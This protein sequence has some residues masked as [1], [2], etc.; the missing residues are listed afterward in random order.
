MKRLKHPLLSITRFSHMAG[1]CFGVLGVC[2]AGQ[3][4]ALPD[5]KPAD[6]KTNDTVSVLGFKINLANTKVVAKPVVPAPGTEVIGL[7]D[8]TL[9]VTQSLN[10]DT[11]F[12]TYGLPKS[13]VYHFNVKGKWGVKLDVNQDQGLSDHYDDVDAGAYYKIT[14]S[15]HVGGSVGVGQRSNVIQPVDAQDPKT[16]TRVRVETSYNF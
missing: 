5:T 7:S 15:L 9:R 11:P 10:Q 8:Q 1:L 4:L 6:N 14:P 3:A 13:H 2:L 12:G 16:K